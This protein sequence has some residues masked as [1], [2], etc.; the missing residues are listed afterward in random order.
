MVDNPIHPETILSSKEILHKIEAVCKRHFADENEQHESFVFILDG[1]KADNFKRLRAYKGKSRLTTYLYS[2]INTLVIDYRRKTYGRRRIP[3]AV[4]KLGKWAEAV[5][6]L[7]CWQKF[8]FDDAYDLL[9]V[10]DS[11]DGPYERYLQ[12]IAPIREAP[13][14]ENPRFQSLD[15]DGSSVPENPHNPDTNPLE[16]LIDKLDHTRRGKALKIIRAAT[17]R[18]SQ[19]D[20]ML[21]RLVYAS[22]QPVTNVA[23]MIGMSAPSARRRLKRLLTQYREQLLAEGI[24][25]S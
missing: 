11:F 10:E 15:E 14:R 12:A 20:Q 19:E 1:L 2:L 16:A 9:R 5:Y 7:V 4:V 24:R 3:A 23:K 25:E 6:R 22:G 17:A 13:C 8:S 21:I 18:L